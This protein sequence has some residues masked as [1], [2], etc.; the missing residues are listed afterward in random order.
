VDNLK[1]YVGLN[2][3]VCGN[4]QFSVLD[5]DNEELLY[6]DDETK[7][8]CSDCGIITTKEQIIQ[9]NTAKLNA[10]LEE[11]TNDVVKEFAKDLKKMFK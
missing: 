8:K 7:I 9:D 4:D 1:K 11:V 3:N 6:A 5:A 2:C 10:N